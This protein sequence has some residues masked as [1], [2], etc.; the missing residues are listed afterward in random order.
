VHFETQGHWQAVPVFSQAAHAAGTM[1]VVQGGR[2]SWPTRPT[3]TRL[4][5][6]TCI[7]ALGSPQTAHSLP[8]HVH[9][10]SIYLMRYPCV[11]CC[12][13][14][15]RGTVCSTHMQLSMLSMCV[16]HTQRVFFKGPIRVSHLQRIINERAWRISLVGWLL[17]QRCDLCERLL[18]RDDNSLDQINE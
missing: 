8:H 10:C 16:K 6:R 4:N 13:H 12:Q 15:V 1:M 3:A 9:S 18:G 14:A 7:D 5:T 2:T 11:R 17:C